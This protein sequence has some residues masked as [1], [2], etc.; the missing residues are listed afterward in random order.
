MIR[1]YRKTHGGQAVR[2]RFHLLVF[3]SVSV[4][5]NVALFANVALSATLNTGTNV[6]LLTP[7]QTKITQPLLNL[8]QHFGWIFDPEDQPLLAAVSR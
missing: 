8:Q 1:V 3:F 5:A 4:L 2:L 7:L 6:N